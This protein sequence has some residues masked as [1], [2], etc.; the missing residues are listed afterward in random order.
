MDE[1]DSVELENAGVAAP[2][3]SAFYYL[4]LPNLKRKF[5]STQLALW[6]LARD[7]VARLS[8]DIA[9]YIPIQFVHDLFSKLP[10]GLKR[11]GY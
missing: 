7:F 8:F 4:L 5:S 1:N 10:R 11:P 3:V 6:R 2:A 9:V